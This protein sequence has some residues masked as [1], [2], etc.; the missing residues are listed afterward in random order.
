MAAEQ[1]VA[2][3][4]QLVL[5]VDVGGTYT[6][7]LLLDPAADA[8][9]V[10]KVL[11]TPADQAQ[12][13]LA[14]LE[15]FDVDGD[16]LRTV[17]H[18][19]TVATNAVLE[20]RGAVC[21]MITTR[22]FRDA[23]ELARRTRPHV[24]GLTGTLEPVIPRELRFEVTERIDADGDVLIP[25]DEEDVREAAKDLLAA[26]VESVV[27]HFLHAYAN[28]LHEQRCGELVRG[29]WPND[30]VILGSEILP[31]I[32]EFERGSTAALNG[33]VQPL[34]GGYL[35]HLSDALR[36]RQI[37]GEL[38]VMQGNGGMMDA[39]LAARHAVHTVMSGPAAGAIAAGRI[40]V[41]S[42][43]A[44]L[45]AC[46]MGGTSFDVSLVINGVPALTREKE[47]DYAMPVHVPMI[48]IHTIGA[49]GGSI[50][51]VD[52]AG[53]LRVGPESAGADPGAIAYGRGGTEPT[54]TDA[55]LVLGRINPDSIT[56][57]SEAADRKAVEKVLETKIG[58][59]LGLDAVAAAE[60]VLTVANHAMAGAIRY[61][62]IEK[63]HDPRDFAL[64]AFGG[65]GPLHAVALARELGI[66]MVLV[67][68]FPG[69]TSA[70]GCALADVRHDF[71]QSLA[72]P[73][74]QVK[75]DEADSLLGEQAAA[76]RAMIERENVAV[77]TVDVHHDA[78]LL[79]DGQSHV[80]QI[81]VSSPGF[82]GTAVARDFAARYRERFEVALPEM[83][84]VLMALRTTVTGRR[85]RHGL[86]LFA[87][88]EP[89]DGAP[90]AERA[91]CFYGAWH[92]TPVFRRRALGTGAA[93]RGP[94]IIEQID[95]T[96]LIG[97]SDSA[98]VDAV[99][100]VVIRVG[101][102]TE[103]TQETS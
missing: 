45:I 48:D 82:D 28:P 74:D 75:G 68:R 85:Q 31:E 5:G 17:V 16:A 86:G 30:Y 40:G 94:A 53:L 49:G 90:A 41:E 46:D 70:V 24:Y 25:L 100:N 32:R 52:A 4:A 66:P 18:G 65:A 13:F 21:G 10:S 59:P 71:G 83:R 84:P 73:L 103:R 96:T 43:F 62:S 56:G 42:G 47:L 37:K 64:F 97:P 20:R 77:D 95:T 89:E 51:R 88:P 58:K 54:V 27:I 36:R 11:T 39:G 29:L 92:A 50:A 80:I 69:I 55:N 22:G 101:G 60:A 26:G 78:D 99:G 1:P 3:D 63:G 14:G 57:I 8:F 44:N 35:G 34:V 9:R 23:L 72:R 19:T 87:D 61:I 67:P 12:G 93:L 98:T 79:Y 76:G 15:A 6:D 91:V 38:L 102:A 81:P 33:Y 7:C 2:G